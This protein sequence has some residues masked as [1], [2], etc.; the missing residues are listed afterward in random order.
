MHQM[1]L[2]DLDC[3]SAGT[4]RQLAVHQFGNQGARPKVYIQAGVH[5]DEL[6]A[7]LAAC[8]LARRLID[9]DKQGHIQGEIILVP[10]AN[11]IGVSNVPAGRLQGRYHLQSGQNFNRGWPDVAE[12][13]LTQLD[14]S[15]SK[16]ADE[17]LTG[18]HHS[19]AACL[20]AVAPGNEAEAL[21]LTLMK[22]AY[23]ADIILDLHTDSEAEMHLYADPDH[24]KTA[25]ELAGLLDALVIMYARAT[26]NGPFEETCSLPYIR[27]RDAGHDVPLPFASVVELRGKSDVSDEMASSDANALLQFLITQGAVNGNA[28]SLPAFNG[29][30]ADFSAT[31]VIKSSA[32][33]IVVFKQKLGTM[34]KTGDTIAQIVNPLTAHDTEPVAILAETDG[35][36]FA[37]TSGRIAWPGSILGKVHGHAV[38]E[39]RTPGAL[40]YD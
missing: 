1:E 24:A 14:G 23:D 29:I 12:V 18:L 19:I 2:I 5:A 27:A 35:R 6:P 4:V 39:N 17:N 34:V 22:L 25:C 40:L 15:W 11:P 38:L 32:T 7:N 30:A 16:S 28:G 26:G 9:E 3:F 21:R 13:A 10:Q 36:F 33:G 31:Q 37:H 8:H 20:D